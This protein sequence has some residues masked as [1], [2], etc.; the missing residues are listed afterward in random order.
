MID[1]TTDNIE[2]LRLEPLGWPGGWR[3]CFQSANAGMEHQLYINGRLT[4]WTEGPQQ[5]TFTL[6]ASRLPRRIVIAA[7][8]PRQREVDFSDRLPQSARQAGW[9][10]RPQVVRSPDMSRSCRLA[11]LG[12]HATGQLDPQP[13]S[14][15]E[16]WPQWAPRW[17]WGE[18]PFASGGFGVDGAQAPGIGQGAFGAG[19]LGVDESL[20]DLVANLVEE[21][22]HQLVLR[23]IEP[24][25]RCADG[26]ATKYVSNPP[27]TPA[28]AL[29]AQSYDLQNQTLILQ[30]E[31]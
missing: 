14:M 24:D 13:L 5:R 22:A 1:F 21:G 29:Q 12:D 3:V 26:P 20:L 7:T 6:A 11:V 31:R 2:M 18:D 16:A 25:G 19:L 4:D 28:R 30:I 10:V 23:A 9:V 17:A 15:V 8:D 27:P